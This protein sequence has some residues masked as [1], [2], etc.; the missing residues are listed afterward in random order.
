[1]RIREFISE[2]DREREGDEGDGE[3]GVGVPF[4]DGM[5]TVEQ[6]AGGVAVAPLRPPSWVNVLRPGLA[7]L[8]LVGQATMLGSSLGDTP[9]QL[10]SLPFALIIFSPEVAWL[11]WRQERMVGWQL[12]EARGQV[13]D[14]DALPIGTV[15]R[16]S[17]KYALSRAAVAIVGVWYLAFCLLRNGMRLAWL[18]GVIGV[19]ALAV[20]FAGGRLREP[21]VFL[22][23]ESEGLRVGR[24]GF[25]ASLMPWESIRSVDVDRVGDQWGREKWPLELA[26]KLTTADGDWVKFDPADYKA[27]PEDLTRSIRAHARAAGAVL[28]KG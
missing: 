8:L 19:T 5:T 3:R 9:P 10:F 20:A 25:R 14:A 18:D 24:P 2:A 1:M 13:G 15:V 16:A 11:L 22:A 12:Q 28:V 4:P 23:F 27:K 26:V 17:A 6:I 7:L 21:R